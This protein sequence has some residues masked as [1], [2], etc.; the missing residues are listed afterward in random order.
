MRSQWLFF[1]VPGLSAHLREQKFRREW[2]TTNDVTRNCMRVAECGQDAWSV[3]RD[4]MNKSR[5][6][7]FAKQG[8]LAVC[9]KAKAQCTDSSAGC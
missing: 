9:R 3:N 4:P 1:G 8:E 7:G 2:I 5:M 6:A